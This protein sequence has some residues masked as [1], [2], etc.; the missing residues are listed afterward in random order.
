MGAAQH[1]SSAKP[2]AM[3]Y[4]ALVVY[5]S[6]YPFHGWQL[7]AEGLF[8]F[9]ALPWPRWWTGFDLAA[10]LVGYAPLGALI[11]GAQVRGGRRP[12]RAMASAWL[13]ASL[14]S[15]A[16][17]LL[18]NLLPQRV[19]SNVDLLFNSFG[20]A[21]GIVLAQVVHR[22]GWVDH[23][24]SVR[25][26]WFIER[27]AGGLALLVLWPIGLLFPT[28]VAL[29][30]GRGLP[31]IHEPLRSLLDG[32]P[33]AQWFGERQA[34]APDL[35]SL[36]PIAEMS[37]IVLG[38][39]APCMVAFTIARPGWPRFALVGVLATLGF[40]TTTLSTALN[41]G[42][43]HGL[44]WLTTAALAGFAIGVVLAVAAGR[45][46]NASCIAFALV[47]L[48]AL[49]VSVAQA[50]EDPYFSQSL[51]AW[52]QGNFIR[53]YGAAQWIGWLWPFLGLLYLL[54]RAGRAA[55]PEGDSSLP[56]RMPP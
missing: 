49:I 55:Q 16:M 52:E 41:F 4:A 32:M 53:F 56:P 21:V 39:L 48:T 12:Q 33:L 6:L 9:I 38:L 54:L 24:Q 35:V 1:Q 25:D 2:L 22:R 5:A 31:R 15:L 19:A 13:L 11:F 27:S 7:S 44:A 8:D 28:P 50:P 10:N 46:S 29:G 34:A 51:H 43:Q 42:P 23:W 30:L 18:Q 40:S 3:L 14:L 17:E 47:V 26:R 37:T 20:A 36:S 45:L